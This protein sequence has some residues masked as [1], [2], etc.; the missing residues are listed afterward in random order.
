MFLESNLNHI[1]P[2]DDEVR[3]EKDETNFGKKLNTREPH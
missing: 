1:K 2:K 3:F